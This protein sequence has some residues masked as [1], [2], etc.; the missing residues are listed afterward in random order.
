MVIFPNYIFRAPLPS[1]LFKMFCYHCTIT[2]ECL[3]Y[4]LIIEICVFSQWFYQIQVYGFTVK[5]KTY[6]RWSS[7][8]MSFENHFGYH[9]KVSMVFKGKITIEW[10]GHQ[11]VP[12]R[13]HHSPANMAV[14]FS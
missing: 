6:S 10:N 13:D 8:L 2:I 3:F 7:Y 11:G 12:N 4:Q 9:C 14:R 5:D 1:M